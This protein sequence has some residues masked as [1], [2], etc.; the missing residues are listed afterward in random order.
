M[1]YDT[2]LCLRLLGKRMN[3]VERIKLNLLLPVLRQHNWCDFNCFWQ[4]RAGCNRKSLC[5]VCTTLAGRFK[6]FKP[7]RNHAWMACI[8]PSNQNHICLHLPNNSR[9]QSDPHRKTKPSHK[10]S[11]HCATAVQVNILQTWHNE[12]G[13]IVLNKS[14]FQITLQ[15]L[16]LCQYCRK[17]VL[18]LGI[19]SINEPSFKTNTKSRKF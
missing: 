16:K 8:F 7:N 3:G 2:C 5:W 11:D 1:G 14:Y 6:A 4:A 12:H 17:F 15:L 10:G 19:T 18:V 13:H 9:W